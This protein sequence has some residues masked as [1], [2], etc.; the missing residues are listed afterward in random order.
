MH[1]PGIDV[2]GPLPPTLQVTTTFSAGVGAHSARPE[3]A[4]AFLAH[5]ASPETAE[6]KR[7]QGMEPA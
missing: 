2:V 6:L 4:R 1:L 7:R 5:L 3:A